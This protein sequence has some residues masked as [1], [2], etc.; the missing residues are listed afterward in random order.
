L[1][2]WNPH[3]LQN[4]YTHLKTFR[5][6]LDLIDFLSFLG[7][8]NSF[9]HGRK[10][11]LEV[12]PHPESVFC[13]RREKRLI[14]YFPP[15]T[16]YFQGSSTVWQKGISIY[17]LQAAYISWQTTS[18]PQDGFPTVRS[19]VT[20]PDFFKIIQIFF[21][22]FHCGMI[23]YS[24]YNLFIIVFSLLPIRFSITLKGEPHKTVGELRVWGVSLG[25]D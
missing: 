25:P 14:I 6:N 7:P 16:L 4:F 18:F 5:E 24:I 22:P 23:Y 15:L 13:Q 1:H 17:Y 12:P 20:F 2:F 21:S 8:I 19:K 11:Y 9:P 3:K 10:T